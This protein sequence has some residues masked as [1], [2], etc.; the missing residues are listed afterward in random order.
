MQS[1]SAQ[2]KTIIQSKKENFVQEVKIDEDFEN[3]LEDE[4]LAVDDIFFDENI[5]EEADPINPNLDKKEAESNVIKKCS[6]EG[7]S[8]APLKG[9]ELNLNHSP[10]MMFMSNA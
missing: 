2:T 4:L 8:G 10:L 1:T 7:D 9:L 5:P 3:L 6:Y